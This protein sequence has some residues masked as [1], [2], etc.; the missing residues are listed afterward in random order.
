MDVGAPLSGSSTLP[1]VAARLTTPP[2]VVT[3]IVALS[4]LLQ[5]VLAWRRPTPGYF[6]DE[7]MY[8][9]L[10]R[11][12]LDSGSPLVRGESAHFL[13]LLYALLTAPAWLWDDVEQAYR[14]IQAVDAVTMS[15]AAVPVFLLA[16]R[17]RVGDRLALAAAALAVV[18]PELLYTSSVLA[19]TLAYPLALATAAAAVA[20]IERP[21]VRLQLAVLGFAGLATLTRLQ[22]AVLPLCYL[23]AVVAVGIRERR[24][25]ATV[26]E[27]V[28]AV[29]AIVLALVAGLGAALAGTVDHGDVTAYSVEPLVAAKGFGANALVLAYAAGWVIVPGAAIGLA[30][31]LTR[32]RLRAEFGFGVFAVRDLLLLLEASVVGDTGRIQE[33]YAMYGLPLLVVAFAVYA[34]RGWP[35]VRAHALLAAIAVTAAA[36]VPLAG[37]AAGGGNSQSIVLAALS[38]LERRLGDVGLASLAFAIGVAVLSAILVVATFARRRLP[39][40]PLWPSRR[41]PR[42]R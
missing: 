39:R 17:L 28:L 36:A 25:R 13:P 14:T 1:R 11:S 21:T 30:L 31:A 32:P 5:L 8:A 12:L 6:P 20:L 18:L 3:G 26:R 4:S 42:L 29:G 23:A 37:Y 41:C 19:E 22:L 24:L 7:Y 2:F 10:A 38:D 35:H 27:H 15:L 16:R 34:H 9:E 33:R 40:R